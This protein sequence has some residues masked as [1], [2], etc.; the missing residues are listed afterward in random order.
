MSIRARKMREKEDLSRKIL[1][2]SRE[3]FIAKGYEHT[4][5]RNIAE[6]IEYSPTT[7]YLYFKDKDAIFHALHQ[8][9]FS[10]LNSRMSVLLQVENP[11]ERLIAMGRIYIGFAM[12]NP[13]FY[14]LMFIQRAPINFVESEDDENGIW[15]EGQTS[16][17]MLKLVVQDCINAGYF[18]FED[19]EAASFLVWSSLHGMISLYTRHRCKVINEVNREQIVQRGYE[20]CVRM[21]K[22]FKN[23]Q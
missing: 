17:G 2:A 3:L 14:D 16:F 10:L 13:E 9:G 1:D 12:E 7:I 21:F 22:G 4:S 11:F 6:K 15:L 18:N 8:E 5:I 19:A 20:E 23:S